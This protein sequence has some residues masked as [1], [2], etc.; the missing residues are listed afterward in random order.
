[1]I[2]L[3]SSIDVQPMVKKGRNAYAQM[4]RLASTFTIPLMDM[5]A[6]LLL[7]TSF[8]DYHCNACCARRQSMCHPG[9]L[10]SPNA[11]FAPYSTRR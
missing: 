4:E 3:P 2:V 10:E 5:G 7:S 6:G 8:N 9:P 1:M 11:V